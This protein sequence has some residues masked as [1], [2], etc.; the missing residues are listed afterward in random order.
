MFVFCELLSHDIGFFVSQYVCRN[1]LNTHL[2]NKLLLYLYSLFQ[3]EFDQ[4]FIKRNIVYETVFTS[5]Q[6]Y[7]GLGQLNMEDN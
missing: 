1:V 4:S 2:Q 6:I 5:L 3:E 7:S